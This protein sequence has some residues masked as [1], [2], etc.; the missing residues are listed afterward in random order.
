M[1]RCGMCNRT[2]EDNRIEEESYIICGRCLDAI[3]EM[4]KNNPIFAEM[5]KMPIG[6]INNE[7]KK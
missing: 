1:V 4:R 6:S 5:L 7:S 2:F 3:E